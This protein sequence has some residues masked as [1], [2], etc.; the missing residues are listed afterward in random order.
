MIVVLNT[1]NRASGHTGG[2]ASRSRVTLS[3]TAANADRSSCAGLAAQKL[4]ETLL[5]VT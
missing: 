3:V 4:E 2:E 1:L 5:W